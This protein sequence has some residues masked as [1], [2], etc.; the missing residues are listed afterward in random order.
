MMCRTHRLPLVPSAKV[1]SVL[2]LVV[3]VAGCGDD[4]SS[5][6]SGRY[7]DGDHA[8]DAGP[9]ARDAGGGGEEAAL[10][11]GAAGACV[12][13]AGAK[14]IDPACALCQCQTCPMQAETCDE[15]CWAAIA[16]VFEFGCLADQ[17]TEIACITSN[18]AEHS[19]SFGKIAA[20]DACIIQMAP[21]DAADDAGIARACT[22]ECEA[23]A[24]N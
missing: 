4:G 7:G 24:G 23:A 22:A 16:C 13:A 9:V 5:D 1:M 17:A 10:D 19:A 12:E 8:H 14:G 21:D 2:A 15:G 6:G 18:C 11:A 20:L 3:V